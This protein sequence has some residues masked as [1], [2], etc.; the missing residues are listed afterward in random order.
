MNTPSGPSV[1]A[2]SVRRRERSAQT[3]A[4]VQAY[5]AAWAQAD[6]DAVLVC[7]APDL[8]FH[9]HAA[10]QC[11]R[12]T[13][14]VQ[15]VRGLLA[16]SVLEAMRYQDRVRVDG[17]VAVLRYRE[18]VRSSKGQVLLSFSACDWLRVDDGLIVEVHEYALL[19][20]AAA[21]SE[22]PAPRSASRRLGLSPRTIAHLLA[23]LHSYFDAQQPFLS[24]GLSLHGV[25]TATGYTRNQISHALNQALGLS[26]YEFVGR[27]RIRH[28]LDHP[29]QYAALPVAE[30][31]PRLGFRALASFYRAFKA[32]TGHTPR[33]HRRQ[34]G[35][36]VGAQA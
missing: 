28:Y 21:T 32:E 3:L 2:P 30:L 22:A 34:R 25:A 33:T 4:V 17:D 27:A 9:D 7:C 15:H 23:D 12:G 10:G 36:A 29:G 13:A 35:D 16:R 18:T 11:H 8:E 20:R 6:V 1:R 26:F 19:E 31:A 24:V 14:A 5:N